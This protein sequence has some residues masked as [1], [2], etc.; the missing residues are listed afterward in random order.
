VDD[1]VGRERIERIDL[2]LA[3][4]QGPELDMLHGA[5]RILREGRLR[6]SSSRRIT[7]PSPT[8]R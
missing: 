2:L 5:D 6:S 3:D 4:V 8:A 1:L 7:T